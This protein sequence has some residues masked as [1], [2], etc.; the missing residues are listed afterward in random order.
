MTRLFDS[1]KMFARKIQL[2]LLA[3][4]AINAI[5]QA[6]EDPK[7]APRWSVAETRDY[8]VKKVKDCL[9]YSGGFKENFDT[10]L[11]KIQDRFVKEKVKAG[12]NVDL[13]VLQY[14][15]A[16]GELKNLRA[17]IES[18]HEK[19]DVVRELASVDPNLINDCCQ[20]HLG[21]DS[22]NGVVACKKCADAKINP[23]LLE[24][25]EQ[26]EE[27]EAELMNKLADLESDVDDFSPDDVKKASKWRI[28]EAT[29][30][31]LK[32]RTKQLLQ[33]LL[34]NELKQLAITLLISRIGNAP[35][36]PIVAVLNTAIMIKILDYML[37]CLTDVI[38]VFFGHKS[39]PQ[40]P[41]VHWSKKLLRL[42]N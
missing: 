28:N 18:G 31:I 6:N 16:T 37:N 36:N 3:A 38:P 30:D 23:Q 7:P 35:L 19:V 29:S 21:K 32:Y 24:Q 8:L 1:K 14:M 25:K 17:E 11:A 27:E 20:N 22:N 9:I 41:P 40:A 33:N 5:V 15:I 12:P 10:T 39:D 2:V 34:Q 13:E 4:L 42:G 26:G